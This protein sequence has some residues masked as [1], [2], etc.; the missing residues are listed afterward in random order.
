[1]SKKTIAIVY[2]DASRED[3]LSDALYET[4]AEVLPRCKIIKPHIEKLGYRVVL[5]PGN[6]DLIK[7]LQRIKPD[8]TFNLVDSMYGRED[9]CPVIPAMLEAARVKYTGAGMEGQLLN[10]DKH[11]TKIV[12]RENGINVPPFQLFTSFDEPVNSDMTFPL[13]VKLNRLHGSVEITQDA[14]VENEQQLKK[15]LKYILTKYK[16]KAI[17]EKY[18]PGTEV[19][20]MIVDDKKTPVI[21]GEERIMFGK[22]K[23]KMFGFE[24]AWSDEDLYDVKKYPLEKKIKSEIKKAFDVLQMRDYA[25]FEIIIDDQGNH[26][27][28]D[29]NSNPAFGPVEA[30]EAFGYLLKMNNIPFQ[31]IVKVIIKNVLARFNVKP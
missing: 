12:M 8:I 15:R 13:I 28:I 18:V 6:A 20:A 22:Q 14:V 17:V 11:L 2:S 29:A 5:I 23:Y 1:M 21:L 27:F 30:G 4:E 9:L 19:T 16:G 3:F 7:A 10:M 31:K 24:E 25:R 26:Y